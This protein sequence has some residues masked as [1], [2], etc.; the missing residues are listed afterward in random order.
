M[1][2]RSVFAGL[3]ALVPTL[4]AARTADAAA[5]QACVKTNSKDSVS[6]TVPAGI[7]KI[8]VQSRSR[9]GVE[10]IDTHFSVKPGQ[11]F[12]ISVVRD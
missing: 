6:W 12:N 5:N 11:T 7:S 9:D 4:L 1:D 3:A 2:R 8:R 10:I